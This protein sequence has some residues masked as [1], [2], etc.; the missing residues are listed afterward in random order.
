MVGARDLSME[1]QALSARHGQSL[2]AA[3]PA[4]T[5]AS[6]DSRRR[7]FCDRRIRARSRSLLLSSQLSRLQERQG[8][9]RPLL[10]D[11]GG[12]GPGRKP[13]RIYGPHAEYFFPKLLFPPLEYQA[14]PGCLEYDALVQ[15]L[16]HNPRTE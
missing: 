2:A 16:R 6:L 15:Q 10:V 1:R 5:S 13:G 3:D 8:R 12:E 14:I 11:G 9:D 7:H 4:A